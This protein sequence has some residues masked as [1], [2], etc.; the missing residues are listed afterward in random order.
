MM[1][2]FEARKTEAQ[3]SVSEVQMANPATSLNLDQQAPSRNS[4]SESSRFSAFEELLDLRETASL[5]GM[6]WKT[7]ET[8]ARTRKIPALKVGKRWRFRVSSLNRWLE[9]EINSNATNHAALTG[10]E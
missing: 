9:H 1:P 5:L 7:L 10:Q 3:G 4:P 8:M 6:H 2:V